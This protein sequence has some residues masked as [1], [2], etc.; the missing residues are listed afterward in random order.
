MDAIDSDAARPYYKQL[1]RYYEEN[2]Q[3][4]L[5][6]RCYVSAVRE[7]RPSDRNLT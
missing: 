1:A 2:R 4:D 6:E 3:Y 5:A 7:R